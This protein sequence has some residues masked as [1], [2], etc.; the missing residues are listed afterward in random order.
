M[1]PLIS[2]WTFSAPFRVAGIAASEASLHI[3]SDVIFAAL[4]RTAQTIGKEML[5]PA[6][7]IDDRL[8][9]SDAL[10]YSGEEAL[11]VPQLFARH[12][13]CRASGVVSVPPLRQE[14][15]W[16]GDEALTVTTTPA[17]SGLYVLVRTT[18]ELVPLLDELFELLGM[19]GIGAGRSVGWGQFTP[20][21]LCL[22]ETLS[23]EDAQALAAG[24]ADE[25]GVQ[26]SLSASQPI[27]SSVLQEGVSYAFLPRRWHLADGQE[28]PFV[29]LA[30]GSTFAT[31]FAGRLLHREGCIDEASSWRLAQPF[32]VG[33][34]SWSA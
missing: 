7:V 12:L 31:R 19:N 2:K 33:V 10:P 20:T 6:A 15:R 18:E 24:I 4:W 30:A 34:S 23:G 1:Q 21:P 9:I 5:L 8:F 16:R 25:S 3:P 32:F 26:M 11:F 28:E 17:G 27:E 13:Y 29:L 22:L 14:C